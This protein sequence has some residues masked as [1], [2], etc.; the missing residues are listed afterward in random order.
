MVDFKIF[1]ISSQI[2]QKTKEHFMIKF[3]I[4]ESF[5]IGF[6]VSFDKIFKNIGEDQ[7]ITL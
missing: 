3:Q 5:F 7:S 4:I 6:K 1:L 2:L